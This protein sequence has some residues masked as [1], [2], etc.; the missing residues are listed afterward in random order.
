[1]PFRLRFG[2]G[3]TIVL[4][5]SGTNP[6]LGPLE[7]FIQDS[8]PSIVLKEKHHCTLQYQLA[9][10]GCSLAKIFGILSMHQGTYHIEDYSVS[11]T[12]LDQVRTGMLC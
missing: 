4:R 8:F 2:D 1:M 9:S 3:Y 10:Y 11:Q 6:N 7:K 5:V 12:T